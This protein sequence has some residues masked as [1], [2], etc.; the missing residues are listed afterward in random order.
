[1]VNWRRKSENIR[2]L[3]STLNLG[4]DSFVFLD[5]N[6]VECGEVRAGCPEVLTLEWPH[7]AAAARRLLAHT[8]ELDIPLVN[9]GQAPGSPAIDVIAPPAF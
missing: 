2:E 5:D 9:P 4:L 3:A 1:M 7:D 6:L 8:W